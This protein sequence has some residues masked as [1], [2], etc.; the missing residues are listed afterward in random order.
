ML[1]QLKLC[2]VLNRIAGLV[3]GHFTGPEDADLAEEV[4][5]LVVYFTQD[6]PVPVMSRFPH[7]HHLPNLTLPLG[8]PV[9]MN[10]QTHRLLIRPGL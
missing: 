8:V 1:T 3:L 6:N 2:G 10:T 5:R 4:E 9:E 7:G